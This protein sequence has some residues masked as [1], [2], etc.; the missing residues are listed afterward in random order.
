[1]AYS[2]S[3]C[4]RAVIPPCF[5]SSRSGLLD[6]FSAFNTSLRLLRDSVPAN[7]NAL[8]VAPHEVPTDFGP[9]GASMKPFDSV[10]MKIS[11]SQFTRLFLNATNYIVNAG[12]QLFFLLFESWFH[13]FVFVCL[14]GHTLAFPCSSGP[15]VD[16]SW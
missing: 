3:V 13:Y 1:M 9:I 5:Q 12:H 4:G 16:F 11:A 14:T 6:D 8:A 15:S 7:F 10:L 2:S